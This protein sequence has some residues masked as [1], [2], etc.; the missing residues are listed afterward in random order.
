MPTPSP[1]I[2]ASVDET[3]GTS[4]MCPSSLMIESDTASPKIAVTMGS[5][6]AVAVPNANSRITIAAAMPM[7]SLLPSSAFDTA[8][9]T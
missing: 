5:A 3:S 4:A 7:S 1:I 2:V 8:L 9:P 6:M